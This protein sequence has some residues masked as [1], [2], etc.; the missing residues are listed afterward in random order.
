MDVYLGPGKE[1]LAPLLHLDGLH[2]DDRFGPV[3]LNCQ[4]LYA[5]PSWLHDQNGRAE[6]VNFGALLANKQL[7]FEYG[8]VVLAAL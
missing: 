7:L 2:W 8:H 6:M 3:D 5:T 1:G 4:L